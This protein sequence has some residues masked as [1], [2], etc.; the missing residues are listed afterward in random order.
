MNA[1]LES[2]IRQRD[3]EWFESVQSYVTIFAQNENMVRT[4]I[5]KFMSII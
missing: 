5:D 1:S 3:M 4:L 2:L